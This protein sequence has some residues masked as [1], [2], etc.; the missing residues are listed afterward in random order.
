MQ[1]QAVGSVP[2]SVSQI[3]EYEIEEA[4]SLQR[5]MLPLEPLLAPPLEVTSQFRPLAEVG[6]DFLDYFVLSDQTVGLYLGDVVG[7]GLPAAFYAALAVGTLRGIHK[8]GQSPADVLELFNRRLHTRAMPKRYCA[9][10]YAVFD[11]VTRELRFSS[12]GLP[13][14]LHISDGSCH[15]LRA[16]GLPPGLFESATYEGHVVKME[17][18][19]SVLL[20]TDGLVEALDPEGEDF[21][22]QALMEVCAEN[23]CET[24]ELLLAR[25]FEAVTQFSRGRRQHDDMTAAVLHL[26]P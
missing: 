17:P 26:A 3:R 7:K 23:H 19:D 10:Q 4:R 25:V 6:G 13:G 20:F 22:L 5:S 8:T 11:P 18:G 9:V 16:E 24:G 1:L 14:P 2:V 21:G 15:E 12:A